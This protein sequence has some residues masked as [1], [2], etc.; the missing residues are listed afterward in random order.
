MPRSIEHTNSF[1]LARRI[2]KLVAPDFRVFATPDIKAKD[3]VLD[4]QRKTIEVGEGA[5]PFDAAGAI[6]FSAGHVLL[7]KDGRY[8]THFGRVSEVSVSSDSAL[9]SILSRQGAAADRAAATWALGIF[10]SNW[11]VSIERATSILEA[12]AWDVKD[13]ENYYQDETA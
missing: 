6:L 11:N 2:A 5:T 1:H 3:V 9:I 4:I 13:W 10:V 12:Y 7:Y 8:P